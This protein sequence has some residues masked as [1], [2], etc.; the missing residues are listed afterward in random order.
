MRLIKRL[1]STCVWM[2]RRRSLREP[3]NTCEIGCIVCVHFYEQKNLRYACIKAAQIE[4]V[5]GLI[6]RLQA[7][8]PSG[9][10]GKFGWECPDKLRLFHHFI[11][12]RGQLAGRWGRKQ[13]L[14]FIDFAHVDLP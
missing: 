14:P 12:L 5:S 2:V 9:T 7:R 8:V 6:F 13:D 1:G 4:S 10:Q 11:K 3:R